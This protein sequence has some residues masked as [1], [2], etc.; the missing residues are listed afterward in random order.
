MIMEP[1]PV[2]S[3]ERTPLIAAGA[4]AGLR[5]GLVS[6]APGLLYAVGSGR[7][8]WEPV[9]L[10]ATVTGL[11]AGRSFAPAPVMLGGLIHIGLSALYGA[12]YALATPSPA[13]QPVRRGLKYGLLLHLINLRLITRLQRFRRLRE[14]TNE[15]V[16]LLAHAVYGVALAAALRDRAQQRT[17]E[18]MHE[19]VD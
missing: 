7:G 13:K 16:E 3:F 10:I 11:P 15:P 17:S 18:E 14:E 5:A 19:P 6:S 1:E 4:A 9:R 8:I 12:V 2:P